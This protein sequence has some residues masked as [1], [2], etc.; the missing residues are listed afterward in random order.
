MFYSQDQLE[1]KELEI[2]WHEPKEKEISVRVR[3]YVHGT[4]LGYV[5][6]K[7]NQ[8]SNIPLIQIDGVKTKQEVTWHVRK[9]MTYIYKAETVKNT[10]F[11]CCIWGKLEPEEPEIE[12]HKLRKKE[13]LVRVGLYVH[14]TI[15]GYGS[16][17]S[18]QYSNTSIFQIDGVTTKRVRW[19]EHGIHLQGRDRE[20]RLSLLLHS[21]S[22][23]SCPNGIDRFFSF[24]VFHGGHF[25]DSMVNYNGGRIDYIDYVSID[26]LSLLDLDDIAIKLKYKLPVEYWIQQPCDDEDNGAAAHTKV[27]RATADTEHNGA[28]V[29]TEVNRAAVDTED[30]LHLGDVEDNWPSGFDLTKDWD[31]LQVSDLPHAT[32]SDND[33]GSD[34]LGSLDGSNDEEGNEG[35]VRKFIKRRIRVVCK[36]EGSIKEQ[37][38]N[39]LEYAIEIKRINP[40][41]SVI[42]KCYMVTGGANPRFHKLYICLGVLKK[43]WKEGCKPILGLD[44]CF[45]K[46][47]H[48][49][50]L[51]TVIGVDPNNHMYQVVYALVES[52]CR[53]T[54]LWFLE[55]L[56]VDLELNNSHGIVWITDKQKGLMD[57]IMEVFPYSE[58]R[59][60]ME[61]S[62]YNPEYS[63][64]YVY[65]VKENR[66]EQ[67]VVNIDQKT[68]ACNKWQLIGIQCIHGMAALSSSN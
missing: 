31:S 45:V 6:S 13:I 64:N 14:G 27:N 49:G 25:D 26:E 40:E 43:G 55:L 10:S 59:I 4:I 39:L 5:R 16:S 67:L 21:G 29:D 17:K 19:E 46:G 33:D 35:L 41:S 48:M 57:A 2:E 38:S 60:K 63:G 42:M 22:E 18:N 3:L 65:Q 52:E 66:G 50:Q 62:I 37:Y 53:E 54:W 15:L 24:R 11:Y 20:E 12:W 47:Y 56:S 23:S 1:P 8:Y 30:N 9:S 61:S 51:L 7:S 32:E 44:G 58:H 28:T 36:D 34:D 68:C